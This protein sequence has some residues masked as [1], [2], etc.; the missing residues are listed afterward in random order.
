MRILSRY[1][2]REVITH[3]AIGGALFTFVLFMKD[4]GKLLEI[5]V[6]NSSSIGGVIEIF[7]YTLPNF[8]IVTI[9]MAILVG[10]LLG[11]SRLAADSEITAMRAAGVGVWRFVRIV[12]AVALVGW[13]LAMA[14]SLYFAPRATSALLQLQDSLRS[15]QASFEVQP[16]VFYENFKNYV[17]YVENVRAT[18]KASEWQH[19]FLAN[20]KDPAAPRVTTA[21]E[22]TVASQ[23]PNTLIM[24]LR[25]GTEH[26]LVNTDQ[27][28]NQYQI[29]TFTESELP[30]ALGGGGKVQLGHSNTPLLAM[31]NRELLAHA[32]APGG[33]RFMIEMEKRFS[34]PAA[35]LVLMLIGIPLGLSSRR[36]GK[37]AGFVLTIA[38]VFIY[39]F[40]ASTGVALARQGKIPV[41]AGVWAANILFAVCGL[42]LLHRMARGDGAVLQIGSLSDLWKKFRGR[43][44]ASSAK[45]AIAAR[46][47]RHDRSRFPLLLDEYILREFLTTFVIVLVGFV[48]LMLLFTFFELL[49]DIIRNRTA[50]VT[51]G[52]YLAN[53]TPDM[54]YTIT[55]LA[56]LI[57]VLVTFGVLA[58]NNEYTAMKATGTSLYRI[59]VPVLVVAALFSL[60]LF[61]FG[62]SYLPAANRRQQA[63]RNM[64]Q[65]K[66]AQTFLRPDQQWIF[67][68]E[69]A[70]QPSRIF[71]YQFFD[72][73][74]NRFA[75]ISV[76]E[77]DPKTFSLTRRIFASSAH[78]EPE[79]GQW[80]FEEGWVRDFSGEQLSGYRKFNLASFPEVIEQPRY[81]KKE[82]LQSQ[83]MSFA[84]LRRYI[85][86]LRQSG[87]DTKSLSVQL[88]GKIAT[89]LI[90]L[91]MAL[92]A[93]PFAL[94]GGKRGS[95]AGFAVAIALAVAY[96]VTESMFVAMGNVNMLP[97]ILA[98]WAP[99]LLFAFLGSYLLLRTPT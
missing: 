41:F 6:R 44:R 29:S 73:D 58:R 68:K 74:H 7:L 40:L 42:L 88:N 43:R 80:I 18:S 79:V 57:S 21:A 56:V 91:I 87:F 52:Q 14:N 55:P 70:G 81:F 15:Q 3:A 64:I 2:W 77:F 72:P 71:Y 60:F 46:A 27:G 92:L 84:E 53:L 20:V 48:A 94:A 33:R 37:S 85:H 66:P 59:M 49:G 96:W 51:V 67:G 63:L 62:Q 10:V 65:G 26:E 5:A 86:D 32:R 39:Y 31:S 25:D 78:W 95:L 22:A 13:A 16:R 98:A 19:V 4:I 34:Y 8:L 38:L 12:L 28:E 36:G 45:P 23:G 47:V 11:L 50:L 89:P 61:L 75:N 1:I 82:A 69:E 17:L 54:I 90:T 35:C 97:A 83:E 99:D 30:I 93:I 24:R 9:P 76:F